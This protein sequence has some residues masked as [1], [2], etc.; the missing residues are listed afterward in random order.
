MGVLI[1]AGSVTWCSSSSKPP[2]PS[3]YGQLAMP[4][5]QH[6][7]VKLTLTVGRDLAVKALT[8]SV[9]NPK[10]PTST[11][12]LVLAPVPWQR[13]SRPPADW[14]R[15]AAMKAGNSLIVQSYPCSGGGCAA[16]SAVVEVTVRG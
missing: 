12:G 6:S 2:I 4:D 10:F 7:P 1:L 11:N 9:V 13:G 3:A 15:F 14:Y 8:G 16:N 5:P